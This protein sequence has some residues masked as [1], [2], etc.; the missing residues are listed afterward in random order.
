MNGGPSFKL[1]NRI[2]RLIWQ[3]TWFA[4][5]AWTPPQWR[6]WRTAIYRLFGAQI[7]RDA[8]I[9]ASARVWAPWHLHM[10]HRSSL[11]PRV[12]CYNMA[13]ISFE[14]DVIVSQGAHLCA[15]SHDIE[16]PDFQLVAAPI[17]IGS[18]CWIAAE[19]FVG[20][21]VSIGE[22]AVLGARSVA[23]GDLAPWTVYVGNPAKPV[24][25][26]VIGAGS[27]MRASS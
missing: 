11:G 12:I 19:A 17:T 10:G 25:A 20:P 8:N 2:L 21:G 24:K 14:D 22:G 5:I 13:M 18:N 3:L 4:L 27:A 9:R 1:R 26:R 16:D 23:F 7:A 6:S 15:G